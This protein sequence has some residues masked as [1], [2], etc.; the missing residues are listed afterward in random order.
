M[1]TQTDDIRRNSRL[2]T[3]LGLA[4]FA[5]AFLRLVTHGPGALFMAFLAIALA[6]TALAL[7][8]RSGQLNG[9]AK[10]SSEQ[11]DVIVLNALE[12]L[13]RTPEDQR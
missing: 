3:M 2:A 9:P 11:A 10:G 7:L 12:P 8:S 5:A 6:M 1:N 4:L 13:H